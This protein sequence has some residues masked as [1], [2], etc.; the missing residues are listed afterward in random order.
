MR[1]HIALTTACCTIAS[2]LS[3]P[4]IADTVYTTDGSRIVGKVEV[5]ASGKLA[6]TTDIAGRLEI[7]AAKVTSVSTDGPVS[8]VF[9]SGDRLV[10]TVETGAG[11]ENAVIHTALGDIQIGSKQMAAL[12]PEGSEDPQVVALREEI[13]KATEAAKPVWTSTLE[14]GGVFKEGN[15]NSLDGKGRFDV[16]RKTS[17]D[18][19]EFFLAA[20]YSETENIRTRNEYRGGVRYE[21]SARERWYWY[22]R[23]G[24]EYDE[25]ENLDLRSTA[26]A[27]F[28]HYWIKK[29]EHEFKTGIGFGYRHESFTSGLTKNS[30]VID[31]GLDY[32]I[33][34]APWL[35]FTHALVYSPDIQDT[36]D[37]RLDLDTAVILPFE[38]EN[39]KL[40]VG[41]RNEYNSAPQPGIERLD[42][43]YYANIV[44]KLK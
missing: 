40:K 18:L 17:S 26:A 23:L 1:R 16:K 8:I 32:R 36:A 31:L 5:L 33:D 20:D 39:L 15:T 29:P 30:A 25:F 21:N 12:W 11:G 34:V 7:D 44:L 14:A 10:G 9:D 35:Q 24:M 37:Y 28:G 43:T 4:A 41:M 13:V 27:G 6:I 42:N 2:L 22:S 38:N 3:A 19:L